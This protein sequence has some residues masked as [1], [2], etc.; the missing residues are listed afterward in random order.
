LGAS[1]R[2]AP[3][4]WA[5]VIGLAPWR[6]VAERLP[7]WA[8]QGK[9]PDSYY[10]YAVG[11]ASD[12]NTR[13]AALEQARQHGVAVLVAPLLPDGLSLSDVPHELLR[14]IEVVHEGKH[15][16][17]GKTGWA[18]WA[19]VSWPLADKS[20]T[21]AFL[22]RR[23]DAV[24][25]WAAASD[26]MRQGQWREAIRLLTELRGTSLRFPALPFTR[27]EVD[28]S[29]GDAYWRGLGDKFAGRRQYLSVVN[30]TC[31]PVA[32]RELAHTRLEEIGALTL[33]EDLRERWGS[34]PVTIVVG[35]HSKQERRYLMMPELGAVLAARLRDAGLDVMLC[36]ESDLGITGWSRTADIGS[37]YSAGSV[38]D[39]RHI[40][41]IL[42]LTTDAIALDAPLHVTDTQVNLTVRVTDVSKP[43]YTARFQARASGH[44]VEWLSTYLADVGIRNYLSKAC[45]PVTDHVP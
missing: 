3:L 4:L 5:A 38:R 45:P 29:L 13:G 18:C 12:A 1:V 19:L 7:L 44:S 2:R 32:T 23:G 41:L 31:A 24:E 34:L 17:K 39:G 11:V 20:A 36:R 35:S 27:D 33:E 37:M 9:R 28:I 26:A 6:L 15:I 8:M 10:V 14:D 25:Q 16:E 40:F 30:S 43:L 42:E 21:L 22:A